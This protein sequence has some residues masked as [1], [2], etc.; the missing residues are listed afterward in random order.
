MVAL[1]ILSGYSPS[2]RRVARTLALA[3][4]SAC[5]GGE[6]RIEEPVAQ[7][8][9]GQMSCA[10]ICVDTKLDPNNCGAC[11]RP[12]AEGFLCSVGACGTEC[13]GGT[14]QC[15][16]R[17]VDAMIDPNNC[18]GCGVVC[19]V[20]EVCK[21]G[22]CAVS[23]GDSLI[24]CN[25]SC[26]D[27][28]T[29]AE[30]CGGCAQ[31]CEEGEVCANGKCFAQSCRDLLQNDP[32]LG[33]GLY[34]IDPD[35]AEGEP[36]FEVSCNMSSDGGGWIE[37]SLDQSQ[38]LLMAQNSA[39]N[40]WHKCADDASLHFGW[41]SQGAVTADFEGN[42]EHIVAL[43][44]VN[45]VSEMIYTVEQLTALRALVTELSTT[46]RMVAVTGDDDNGDWQTTMM[47][48]HE[49][50]IKGASMSW[51]LLTPGED[52]D[53]GGGSN[54]PLAGSN[55]AF[56]LWHTTAAGSDAQG[57]T[58]NSLAGLGIG[59]ILPLEARLVVA[60]GGGVAFGWEKRVFLVR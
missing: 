51:V 27:I 9:E 58:V 55:S 32:S 25:G 48:G 2:M 20:N 41:I 8:P 42:G 24:V 44:Y 52:G 29:N 46:T 33:S 54:W 17:C 22:N 5:V 18:G 57:S 35:G 28:G 15:D 4:V 34:F 10:G 19:A 23:C 3:L 40:P 38:N 37:L 49:V 43:S 50:Y 13:L 30:H 59:D 60:S 14:T 36:P 1:A 16:D 6:A 53:C 21:L 47:S 12:C 31:P 7:C 26:V 56:Y 39:T 11:D 45:P